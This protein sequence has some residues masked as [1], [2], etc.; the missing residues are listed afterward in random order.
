[1]EAPA[2]E[3]EVNYIEEEKWRCMEEQAIPECFVPLV[4]CRY[5]QPTRDKRWPSLCLIDNRYASLRN[6]EQCRRRTP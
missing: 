4:P 6:C 3:D 2:E 1:M 5:S